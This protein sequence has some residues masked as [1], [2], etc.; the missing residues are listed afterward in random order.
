MPWLDSSVR[1]DAIAVG[2][3]Q[4][5]RRAQRSRGCRPLKSMCGRARAW[6][7]CPSITESAIVSILPCRPFASQRRDGATGVFRHGGRNLIV[8]RIP[9]M[10]AAPV[11]E[12]RAVDVG[13]VSLARLLGGGAPHRRHA[14]GLDHCRSRFFSGLSRRHRDRIAIDA[15]TARLGAAIISG[16]ARLC[17]SCPCP[18]SEMHDLHVDPH[19]SATSMASCRRQST[20]SIHRE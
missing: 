7:L 5:K 10:D 17:P 15:E 6:R 20:C 14:A 9:M 4:G 2:F 13:P 11:I 16:R 1:S 12:S 18:A 8:A 3:N 19:F